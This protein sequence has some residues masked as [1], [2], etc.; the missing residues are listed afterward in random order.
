MCPGLTLNKFLP[1]IPHVVG[2]AE[3]GIIEGVPVRH[4][5]LRLADPAKTTV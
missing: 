2:T 1:R 3:I 5:D 4:D